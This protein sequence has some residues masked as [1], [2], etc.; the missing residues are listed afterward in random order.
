MVQHRR[1]V[2]VP[3]ADRPRVDHVTSERVQCVDGDITSAIAQQAGDFAAQAACSFGCEAHDESAR[4]VEAAITNKESDAG[5]QSGGLAAA[6]A[7]DKRHWSVSSAN[8]MQLAG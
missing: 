5:R 4:G 3:E 2:L 8:R 7:G 1:P 6:G